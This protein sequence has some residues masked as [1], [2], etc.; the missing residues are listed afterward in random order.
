MRY[1]WDGILYQDVTSVFDPVSLHGPAGQ[2]PTVAGHS[3]RV[4][5][6]L[7]ARDWSMA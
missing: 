1:H 2:R 3:H 7:S 5:P 4:D 6:D